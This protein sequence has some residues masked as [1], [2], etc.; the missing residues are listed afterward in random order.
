MKLAEHKQN[1]HLDGIEKKEFRIKASAKAFDILSSKLYSNPILA[2]VRELSTNAVDA[3]IQAGNKSVKYDVSI[4]TPMTPYYIIRDYGDGLTQDAVENIFTTIFESTKTDSN[5]VTGCLGLGS[6]SPFSYVDSYNVDSYVDGTLYHY[7]CFKDEHGIPCVAFLG[8]ESTSE[9]NGLKITIAVKVHDCAEFERAAQKVYPYLAIKPNWITK[10]VSLSEIKYVEEG[11]DWGIVEDGTYRPNGYVGLVAIMGGVAYPVASKMDTSGMDDVEKSFIH[12][13]IDLKLNIGDVDIEAGREGLQFTKRTQNVLKHKFKK[14]VAYFVD[15]VQKDFNHCK[16]PWEAYCFANDYQ[17]AIGYH[18]T[19]YILGKVKLTINGKTVNPL[20]NRIYFN[21]SELYVFQRGGR[22]YTKKKT[23][24]VI[25][26]SK[27]IVVWDDQ[28]KASYA[29]TR[30]Y[31]E[32]NPNKQVYFLQ[33]A[34]PLDKDLFIK[35]MEMGPTDVIDSSTL[36]K[37]PHVKG[38]STG[39]GATKKKTAKAIEYKG[40]Y[41]PQYAWKD[42]SLDVYSQEYYVPV[43]R[44]NPIHNGKV[45]QIGVIEAGLEALKAIGKPF[46]RT[47]YG[48]R[49]SLIEKIKKDSKCKVI[50]FFEYVSKELEAADAKHSYIQK[51]TDHTAYS[52]IIGSYSK[53][54]IYETVIKDKNRISKSG[55]MGKFIETLETMNHS[56]VEDVCKKVYRFMSSF[57]GFVVKNPTFDLTKLEKAV[58]VRYPFLDCLRYVDHAVIKTHLVDYINGIDKL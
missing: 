17:G 26:S 29:R 42:S 4:P 6:K 57:Q 49:T 7:T 20:N 18:I 58:T 5:D 27:T 53:G 46:T 11:L 25:P 16:T 31:Q 41:S 13:N 48:V 55:V 10:Q 15:K 50:N 23:N 19:N 8:D 32:Q 24:T 30:Y 37:K 1:L 39:S 43:E 47:V 9:K 52:S 45:V 35:T 51:Y 40:G 3:H 21:K 44:Y 38:V 36:P 22:G 2:I 28:C 56:A 33:S 12:A 54:R 14:I 34:D